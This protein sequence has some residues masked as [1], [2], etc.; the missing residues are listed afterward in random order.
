MKHLRIILAGIGLSAGLIRAAEPIPAV[1]QITSRTVTTEHQAPVVGLAPAVGSGRATHAT[2]RRDVIAA[3]E[4]VLALHGNPPFAELVTN[5]AALAAS[6]R[7]RLDAVRD[8]EKLNKEVAELTSRRVE[9]LEELARK[10]A[11]LAYARDQTAK[12]SATIQRVTTE[13]AR[14]QTGMAADAAPAVPAP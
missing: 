4:Q 11:E 13:L 9:L 14:I 8:R 5:D 2:I 12:L 1:P 3:V 6:L 10:E 7:D